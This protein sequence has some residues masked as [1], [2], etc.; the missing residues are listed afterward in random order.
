[1]D[2]QKH[3]KDVHMNDKANWFKP[4]P[5]LEGDIIEVNEATLWENIALV[6][7]EVTPDDNEEE[8]D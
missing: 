7:K 8:E 4:V 5:T 6:K 2:L 1:M 3:M